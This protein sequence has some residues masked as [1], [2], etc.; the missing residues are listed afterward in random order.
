MDDPK[1]YS[2]IM[3]KQLAVPQQREGGKPWQRPKDIGGKGNSKEGQ[4]RMGC[5]HTETVD[6]IM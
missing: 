4:D 3:L 1:G 5:A 2:T 6:K